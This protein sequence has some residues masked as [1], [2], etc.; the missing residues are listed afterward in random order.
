MDIINVWR[1]T[2][3]PN[4]DWPLAL[5]DF[6]SVNMADLEFND[7]IHRT[8]VGESIR[9]Y[10]NDQHKWYFLGDQRTEEVA[11]FR[12]TDSRGFDVPFALHLAF[13]DP[14]FCSNEKLRESIEVRLAC[15]YDD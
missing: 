6:R 4:N 13:Q 3:G 7:V 11:I 5:C 12:N 15:F 9:A 10:Q 8:Y 2:K 14:R 1:V